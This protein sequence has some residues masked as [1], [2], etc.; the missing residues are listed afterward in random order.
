MG[1]KKA[2]SVRETNDE[3]STIATKS[4]T[5]LNCLIYDNACGEGKSGVI[6]NCNGIVFVR[7]FN[8]SLHYLFW[9]KDFVIICLP[10]KI[11]IVPV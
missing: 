3:R 5:F 9:M 1:R 2:G 10:C 7:V 4:F 6:K 8:R 11:L